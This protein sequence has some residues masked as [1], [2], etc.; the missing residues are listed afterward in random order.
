[1]T[2][3]GVFPLRVKFNFPNRINAITP[4]QSSRVKIFRFTE[5]VKQLY[6]RRCPV[7]LKGALARSSRTLERDAVDADVPLTN[8]TEA[9]GEVVWS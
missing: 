6:V 7:P 5:R 4:V 8:G 1:M 2:I 3:G 9:D